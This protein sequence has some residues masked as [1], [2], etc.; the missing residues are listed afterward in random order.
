ME[1]AGPRN[2]VVERAS[3]PF[4]EVRERGAPERPFGVQ[5]QDGTFHRIP[6]VRAD[7]F[8]VGLPP[9]LDSLDDYEP[10]PL[11]A[12]EQPERVAGGDGIGACGRLGRKVLDGLR[13]EAC[14]EASERAKVLR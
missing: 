13:A 1:V 7:R 9:A 11:V 5:R 10:S 8:H 14:T 4:G 3:V 12:A 6:E 2:V